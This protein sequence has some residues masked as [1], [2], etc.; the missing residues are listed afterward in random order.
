MR[1]LIRVRIGNRELGIGEV[2]IAVGIAVLLG[3]FA[4][5]TLGAL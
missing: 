1:R 4:V 3:F 5:T 2:E